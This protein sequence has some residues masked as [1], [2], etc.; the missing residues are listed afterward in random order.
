MHRL[1]A[2]VPILLVLLATPACGGRSEPTPASRNC[3]VPADCAPGQAC[4]SGRC[5]TDLTRKQQAI[6][7]A[8]RAGEQVEAAQRQAEGGR[9]RALEDLRN[10]R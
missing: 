9:D 10:Q 7:Q 1:L 5:M 8:R 2:T 3:R 4:V 6:P